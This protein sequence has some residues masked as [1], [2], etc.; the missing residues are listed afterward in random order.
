MRS[1]TT[2]TLSPYLRHVVQSMLVP[3]LIEYPDNVQRLDMESEYFPSVA[4]SILEIMQRSPNPHFIT[5]CKRLIKVCFLLPPVHA[6]NIF[7][8]RTRSPS[9]RA[10]C[11]RGSP[12]I[13]FRPLRLRRLG[14]SR[15]NQWFETHT[16]SR[17]VR[18]L[19][20]DIQSGGSPDSLQGMNSPIQ[21]RQT[22]KLL[23]ARSLPHAQLY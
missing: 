8:D 16:R 4:Q 10:S 13:M 2:Q 5:R 1:H 15:T 17:V 19:G 12:L 23:R 22:C 3:F 7:L 6:T 11:L 20:T 21:E 14:Q 18:V 9:V